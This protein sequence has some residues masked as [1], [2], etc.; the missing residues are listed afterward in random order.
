MSFLKSI[1]L[2]ALNR[3]TKFVVDEWIIPQFQ[4]QN[5]KYYFTCTVFSIFN[6][7]IDGKRPVFD[8]TYY[9][10]TNY[11]RFDRI[12]QEI[13]KFLLYLLLSMQI[14]NLLQLKHGRISRIKHALI[15]GKRLLYYILEI[16]PCGL[17]FK[18]SR[19]LFLEL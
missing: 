9:K 16:K 3:D 6:F 13:L 14:M 17:K 2:L 7:F 10:Y 18:N 12:E 8:S 4:A 5:R 1:S 15:L 19:C 11:R